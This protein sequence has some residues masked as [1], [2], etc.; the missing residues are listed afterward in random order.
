MRLKR[1]LTQNPSQPSRIEVFTCYK[2]CQ[3]GHKAN[4]S[5]LQ[6]KTHNMKIKSFKKQCF[7]LL[8]HSDSK[9]TLHK[10]QTTNSSLSNSLNEEATL[11]LNNCNVI[12]KDQSQEEPSLKSLRKLRHTRLKLNIFKNLKTYY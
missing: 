12:T 7:S 1:I 9:E 5:I 3:V 8:I 4:K 11:C 2:F 6:A 10:I